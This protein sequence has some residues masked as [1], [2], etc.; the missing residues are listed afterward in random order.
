MTKKQVGS[1]PSH[2]Q[3]PAS[4]NQLTLSASLVRK[5]ATTKNS[6]KS[7]MNALSESIDLIDLTRSQS[8]ISSDMPKK[9]VSKREQDS[10]FCESKTLRKGYKS[11]APSLLEPSIPMFQGIESFEEKCFS[12]SSDNYLEDLPSP[13]AM[14]N[15]SLDTATN[16]IDKEGKADISRKS[17]DI[18]AIEKESLVDFDDSFLSSPSNILNEGGERLKEDDFVNDSSVETGNTGLSLPGPN[19]MDSALGS[20]KEPVTNPFLKTSKDP[21]LG[22]F[23]DLAGTKGRKR[24]AVLLKDAEGID[25]NNR[26]RPRHDSTYTIGTPM[27][28]TKGYES[29]GNKAGPS[30]LSWEGIDPILMEEFKDLVNLF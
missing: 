18:S 21:M 30:S 10:T 4:L 11:P 16:Y 29:C 20:G 24:E 6:L 19:I 28:S 27:D 22:D 9:N 25:E 1:A 14:L 15:Q 23:P 8:N 3:K 12:D 17:D 7:R 26:K 13:S 2:D 5:D